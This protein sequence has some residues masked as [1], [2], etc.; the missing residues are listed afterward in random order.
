MAIT[1]FQYLWINWQHCLPSTKNETPLNSNKEPI[2]DEK[3]EDEAFL[4]NDL[5]LI[6]HVTDFF[7]FLRSFECKLDIVY[8][9]AFPKHCFLQ[10]LSEIARKMNWGR[11]FL[12]KAIEHFFCEFSKNCKD[13][14]LF[15]QLNCGQPSLQMFHQPWQYQQNINDWKCTIKSITLF[16]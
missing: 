13:N 3:A 9:W 7:F 8:E 12:V 16:L 1:K 15:L 11:V 5:H 2:W 6:I 14:S 10:A 4:Q